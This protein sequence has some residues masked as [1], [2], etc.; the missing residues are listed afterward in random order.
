[1]L[2]IQKKALL[3]L[4][5]VLTSLNAQY[6]IVLPD[7]TEYGTLEVAK[8]GVRTRKRPKPEHPHGERAAWAASQISDMVVGEVRSLDVVA[9]GYSPKD[10]RQ[11]TSALANRLW[12]ASNYI[13][14]LTED[15]KHVEI[16][17]L[18]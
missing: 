16:M 12:G 3:R 18:A 10:A 13:T 9:S 6:K 2:D 4:M 5:G 7:G 11:S 17:R 8:P 1:M 14:N 15:C